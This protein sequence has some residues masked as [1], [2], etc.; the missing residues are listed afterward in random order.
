MVGCVR[1]YIRI[2]YEILFA[3]VSFALVLFNTVE[4]D[5]LDNVKLN[6]FFIQVT[7]GSLELPISDGVLGLIW[8]P[9]VRNYYFNE[10]KPRFSSD[11]L[12]CDRHGGRRLQFSKKTSV[13]FTTD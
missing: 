6:F 4:Y 3:D 8:L 2:G 13:F 1:S 7:I 12:S 10:I 5:T 11:W 9:L